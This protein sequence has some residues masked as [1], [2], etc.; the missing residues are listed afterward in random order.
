MNST[1][2]ECFGVM[3]V[4]VATL[5]SNKP[6]GSVSL[7]A[8]E[9]T[10]SASLSSDK[11]RFRRRVFDVGLDGFGLDDFSLGGFGGLGSL[12]AVFCFL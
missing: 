4:S 7:S 6:R 5:P 9:V 1:T 11:T 8:D 2:S 3:S 12:I 10:S